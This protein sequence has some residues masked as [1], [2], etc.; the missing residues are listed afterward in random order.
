MP[1]RH[2]GSAHA[3][4]DQAMLS[5]LIEEHERVTMARLER[6]WAYFRNPLVPIAAAGQHPRYRLAQEA[7]LPPRIVGRRPDPRTDDRATGRRE[8][9]IENDIAWRIHAMIDFLFGRPLQLVSAAPD[10]PTRDRIQRVLEAVWEAS[11]GVGMLQD[12][13]LLGH[14]FGH[15]DFALRID[16][17]ALLSAAGADPATAA[18]HAI[19]IE[20]IDPRR[21]IPAVSP[22]DYRELDAYVIRFDRELNE[23]VPTPSR[24]ARVSRLFGREPSS[25]RS[26]ARRRSTV[27]EVFEPGLWRRLEDGEEVARAE[28]VLLPDVVPIVHA[29]NM[30]QPFV[31]TGFGEVEGLIPLQDELNT[32]LS[33]RANRVTMQSF[34]MYLAKRMGEGDLTVGPGQVWTAD[35][36]DASVETFGGDGACPSEDAHVEQI[37]EALDKASGVPPVAGGVLRDRVGNLSSAMALRVTLLNL[38]A[39]TGRKRV[40]YGRA[41]TELCELILRALDGAGVLTTSEQDRVVRVGWPDPMPL[42]PEAEGRAAAA[43]VAL[44]AESERVLSELGYAAGDPGIA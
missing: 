4:L 12:A 34:R 21:G 19:R 14:V 41:I 31:Y 6:N 3:G 36:P 32:R 38:L 26:A 8:V 10:E 24:S 39:K 28:S 20:P 18:A 22:D 11:G 5:L 13:A 35:D 30:S 16:E 33:D 15:V 23:A 43:R 7:G 1:D 17:H 29:Q 2:D 40:T 42:D 27:T 25:Q 44:G 9:V 37:R